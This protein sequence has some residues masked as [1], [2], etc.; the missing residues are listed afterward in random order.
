MSSIGRFL[1]R[2]WFLAYLGFWLIKRVVM[3]TD[4]YI[5]RIGRVLYSAVAVAYL[6]LV[7]VVWGEV[8]SDARSLYLLMAVW[9]VALAP[10]A[11]FLALF[12]VPFDLFYLKV[13]SIYHIRSTMVDWDVVAISA[14]TIFSFCLY[15][16]G[17]PIF[18]SMCCHL[19]AALTGKEETQR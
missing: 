12:A 4:P 14:M 7:V 16:S 10:L 3:N 17:P 6:A 11:F 9:D 2:A 13:M 18:T 15:Y 8:R 5:T 1:S 19:Y